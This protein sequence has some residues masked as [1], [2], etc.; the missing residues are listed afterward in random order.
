MKIVSIGIERFRSIEKANVDISNLCAL[1]GSNNVG[2]SGVL[3]ALNAF[4]NFDSERD[5]FRK[6]SHDYSTRGIPKIDI[7]FSNLPNLDIYN[8]VRISD[9]KIHLR[10]TFD[11]SKKLKEKYQFKKNNSYS[12]LPKEILIQIFKD[13]QFV[14][15]PT[16]RDY[17][18][19]LFEGKTLLKEL[20]D[21]YLKKHTKKRNRIKPKVE[22]AVNYFN[23]NAL[24]KASME[25]QKLYPLNSDFK[26]SIDYDSN[27]IDYHILLRD[28]CVKVN[29]GTNNFKLIDTGSGIQSL[30]NIAIYRLLS[31]L[32]HT[33]F[34]I[35][36][37]EPEINLHPQSQ[38][39]LINE[40]RKSV[41]DD[42]VQILFTSHSAVV[43][44]QLAH[45]E[46]ISFTK[47]KDSK[48]GFKS[49][50]RQIPKDF[51]ERHGLDY[52]GYYQFYQYHNSEF[53]FAKFVIIVEGKGDVE[54]LK[55]LLGKAKIDIDLEGISILSLNGVQ[56]LKYPYYLLKYL[57]V[58]YLV[59]VD[60]DFFL[61]YLYDNKKDSRTNSGFFRYKNEYQNENSE[62]IEAIIDDE[63]DRAALLPLLRKNHN[64]ALNIL[65]RYRFVCMRY[66]L[67]VDLV[68]C[69][70][71]AAL[72]YDMFNVQEG[73]RTKK[74]LLENNERGIKKPENIM[75]VLRQMENRNMPYA[76][77]RIKS[78][79]KKLIQ[80]QL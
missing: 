50:L 77:S 24:Q 26:I 53:F 65:E 40:F 21:V 5:N 71:A 13:V 54:V 38:R 27:D 17:R 64:K 47:I 15:I 33:N 68:D 29:D 3:R 66:T 28:L 18:E 48:R 9:N 23:K 44:D 55:H 4:F 19:T 16:N 79:S 63:A 49:L 25:L 30:V 42:S 14:Y 78:V 60:K 56:E 20:L 8:D 2:K 76:Y 45:N 62:I 67:E 12:E 69:E 31:K 22:D 61:P 80:N 11:S 46:I 58:P 34:I 43:I 36:I 6:G 75:K 74:F 70:S 37:E 73:N 7:V 51:W 35:G 72:Y 39:E 52:D 10:L 57:S 59:I 41:D 1:V 32:K